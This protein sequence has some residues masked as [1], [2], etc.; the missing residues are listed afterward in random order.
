MEVLMFFTNRN[1]KFR[2]CALLLSAAAA[3]ATTL[4]VTSASDS[5]V[6]TLRQ[7]NFVRIT[8]ELEDQRGCTSSQ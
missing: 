3:Q 2:G 5:G 6:G 4:T 8:K 1:L 7:T